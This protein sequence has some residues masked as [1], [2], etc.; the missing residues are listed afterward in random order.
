MDWHHN[1]NLQPYNTFG[2]S[3]SAKR[4]A[5]FSSSSELLDALDEVQKIKDP[6][7]VLGGGS[8][9]LLVD[10]FD[11]TVLRNEIRRKEITRDE[12]DYVEVAVGAG[13]NWHEFVLWTIENGWG[14]V[15]NLSL[16]PGSVGAAP[17]QNIGAYG[18]E[19][20]S[21]FLS[22][23]AIEIASLT[24]RT[25][26]NDE[27]EFGYRWSVFKGAL[28]NKYI[29]TEV[30]FRLSKNPE[31]H[32]QYGAIQDQLKENGVH[33]RPTIKQVSD[34]VIAIRKSKLPDPADIGNSGSFFKNPIVP[35]EQFDKLKELFPEIA[36]YPNGSDH[37]KI[38][39]G[40]LIDQLGWK[41]FREGDFGVHA[42]QA[43]VLVNYG[44][45]KGVDIAQLAKKIQQDVFTKFGVGLEAEVN[46]IGP[47]GPM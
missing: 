29:I 32:T 12:K 21:S 33:D 43:L 34:A 31:T 47:N 36:A 26:Y 44:N 39:A 2:L 30:R 11:G 9:L 3:A 23:S 22:C 5:R 42:K 45:A 15:E 27:C 41:G 10:N 37:T 38:A 25:F 20:K 35:N 7:L 14:G 8:N 19:Q 1:F 16:I 13:E 28:K 6:L 40:W 17:I 4:F 18:V 46:F 24:E